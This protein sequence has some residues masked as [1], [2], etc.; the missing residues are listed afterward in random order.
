MSNSGPADAR[1]YLPDS[2][3]WEAEI[4]RDWENEYCF[5]A[6]PGEDFFHLLVNGE[7]YLLKGDEKYCLNCAVRLGILTHDREFW[8]KSA[9]STEGKI[10]SAADPNDVYGLEEN[11]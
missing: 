3:G 10:D 8:H 11:R 5:S 9:G 1:V 6:N 2:E 4:K 7:I